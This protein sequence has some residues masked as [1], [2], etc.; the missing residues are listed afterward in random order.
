MNRKPDIVAAA[1]I[2]YERMLRADSEAKLGKQ[3][4]NYFESEANASFNQYAYT[5]EYVSMNTGQEFEK[6]FVY[7]IM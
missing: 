3:G 4:I 1:D 2:E 6:D 7:T 5:H